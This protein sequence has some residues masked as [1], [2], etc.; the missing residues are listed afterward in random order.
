MKVAEWA[1]EVAAIAVD[2]AQ[3]VLD[4]Q[5]GLLEI[6]KAA[7]KA[8]LWVAQQ[9]VKG[10]KAIVGFGL[11]LAAKI[12]QGALNLFYLRKFEFDFLMSK[13]SRYLKV[14]LDATVFGKDI[15]LDFTIDFTSF[16]S[17]IKSLVKAIIDIIKSIF[18]RRRERRAIA[19]V[20][21]ALAVPSSDWYGKVRR[22]ATDEA[23]SGNIDPAWLD[24][25]TL[26]LSRHPRSATASKAYQEVCT[27]SCVSDLRS[28]L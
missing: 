24:R 4:V 6:A 25:G 3:V 7:Y 15:K 2:A 1:V 23:G 14:L 20:E 21:S 22:Y 10:V 8:A 26:F 27:G 5:I 19:D 12:V 18:S 16:G 9:A 13:E 17:A 11:K 28:L